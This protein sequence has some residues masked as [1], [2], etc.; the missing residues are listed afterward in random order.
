MR[1]FVENGFSIDRVGGE[2]LWML[3]ITEDDTW[4]FIYN[5]ETLQDLLDDLKANPPIP[6]SHEEG[7]CIIVECLDGSREKVSWP[8]PA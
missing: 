8:S 7:S 2:L 3:E 4:D 5:T 1:R 6:R